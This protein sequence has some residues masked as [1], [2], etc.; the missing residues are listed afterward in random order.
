MQTLLLLAQTL[1]VGGGTVHTMVPGEAPRVADVL[2]VDGR[3]AAVG[4]GLEAPEGAQRVDAAGLHVVP[5]LIDGM[6]YHDAE[7]DLLYT[8]AGVT[9]VRDHGNDLAAIFAQRERELRDAR[10]GPWL[11]ISGAVLDGHPPSSPNALVL[12]DEH[13]AHQ[14]LPKLA[15][16]GIDFVS[17]QSNLGEAAWREVLA[18]AHAAEGGALQVWGPRPRAISREAMLAG[19]QDGLVFLDGL[20]P[21]GRGWED[22]TDEELAAAARAAAE[23]GLRVTP[24]LAATQR[25]THL[26]DAGVAALAELGPRY[27]RLWRAELRARRAASS[28]DFAE[29]ALAV[30]AKQGRLVLALEE[31]GVALVPGSGAP[32]PWLVPG[33]GLI[34]ELALWQ[35]AG[36]PAAR[37]LELATSAAAANLALEDRGALR[38]G[39][40]ADLVLLGADPGAD[41]AA[42]REVRGVVLRGMSLT[43]ADLDAALG[44][45][46]AAQAAAQEAAE[47]GIAVAPPSLPQGRE[48]LRGLVE[49]RTAA[50][51][52][53]AERWSIVEGVEGSLYF[54]GRRLMPG[55]AERASIE[56]ETRQVVRGDKL[57][58]FR[59]E[60]RTGGHTLVVDGV[61]VGNQ[62]RVERRYDGGF[63]DNQSAREALVTL[64]V[65]SVTTLLLLA[66]VAKEGPMPVLRFDEA[67][68]LEV[69]RWDLRLEEDGDHALRTPQGYKLASFDENGALRAALEVAG[70]AQT[71]L[72]STEIDAFGG[73]GLPLPEAKRQ[74]VHAARAAEAAAAK[75]REERATGDVPEGGDDD[76]R[77]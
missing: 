13:T 52:I 1:L 47:R 11:S 35:Q 71:Q 31:A 51:T 6:A 66:H 15:E 42:L 21:E 33:R 67:L 16:E 23:A 22:V 70:A 29:R 24:V 49:S 56:V 46:R 34:D 73:P 50:G 57:D 10:R 43:R 14:L 26:Q 7:H 53:A 32:H 65:S 9:L 45:L 5:G 44:A 17:V 20:L 58:S 12:P 63:V 8:A 40:V 41:V 30:L 38:E 27:T 48:V 2:V 75:Q 64:D 18:L 72:V 3:V 19:P 36:L 39:A 68:E 60:L 59:V 77:R 76:G 37:C 69:V 61:L 28:A 55:S 74:R 62:M 54:L 25:L 4:A